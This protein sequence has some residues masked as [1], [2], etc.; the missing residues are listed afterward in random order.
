MLSDKAKTI[1]DYYKRTNKATIKARLMQRE[2]T[3]A[4]ENKFGEECPI[5]DFISQFGD[6]MVIVYK[7]ENYDCNNALMGNAT[8]NII[9]KMYDCNTNLELL[10]MLEALGD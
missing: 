7:D 8:G 3:I 1:S 2:L 10:A 4:F 6:G 9:G 5:V